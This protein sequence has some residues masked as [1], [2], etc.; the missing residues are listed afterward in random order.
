MG[1]AAYFP[2]NGQFLVENIDPMLCTHIIYGY[3]DLDSVT[4]SIYSSYSGIDTE[5]DGGKGK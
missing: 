1:W 5:E 3:A 2:G 4:H